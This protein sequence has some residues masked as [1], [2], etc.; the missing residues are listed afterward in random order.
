MRAF[1]AGGA[2]WASL[3]AAADVVAA[4]AAAAAS[5]FTSAVFE[6]RTIV[7]AGRAAAS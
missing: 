5:G 6:S 7:S 2:A 4:V 1:C 3:P